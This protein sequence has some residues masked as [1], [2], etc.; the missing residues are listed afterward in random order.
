MIDSPSALTAREAFGRPGLDS[1]WATGAKEG[2]GTACTPRS[3]VWF[4]LARGI[5]TEVYY[6]RV[7]SANT[8]DLQFLITDG[9]TFF[10]EEQRDLHHRIEYLDPQALAY[11]LTNE[12]PGGRYRIVKHVVTDPEADCLLVRTRFEALVGRPADY[13]LLAPRVK[14]RG[15]GNSGEIASADGATVLTAWREDVALALAASVPV[16]RASCGFVGVSDG[17]T[18]LHQDFTMDWTFATASGGNIALTAELDFARSGEFTLALGFGRDPDEAARAALASLRKPYAEV[19]ARYVQE[20]QE[21]C[22]S[23]ADLSGQ[24]GDGGR[25]Q[26][27]SAMVLK[28]HEDKTYR[29]AFVASLSVP[30]GEAAGDSN[31]GGYHLCWPRDLVHIATGLLAVGDGAS[32]LRALE[33]LAR[34]QN[35]ADGSW[36]QNC[37]V[38]GRPYW[39]SLQLDEVAFPLLLAARLA[40]AGV[41]ADED[42][43]RYYPMVRAAALCL[44]R[45]GP[46]TPQERWEENAGYSPATLAVEIAALVCAAAFAELEAESA[47][48]RYLREVADSWSTRLEDWT[49]TRCGG[50]VSGQREYYERIA[51]VRPEELDLLGTECRVFLPIA[52]RRD[53]TEARSQCCIVD[54]GF[55]ELVRYG[56]RAADDP[57]VLKTLPVYDALL[58]VD[59]P[60]GPAWRRYN[61]DGYGEGANGEPYDGAGIG[62]AWPLL[63]G[64]RGH[65]ELAAG[66]DALSYIQAMG[67]FA[68]A[69]GMLPEQVWDADDLPE[70]GLRRGHGTGSAT[71]L[72]WAHAEYLRLLRSRRDGRV[73]D[74]IPEVYE[75][76]VLRRT[77]T[78]LVIWKFNHLVRAIGKD[79]RLRVEV[80][81][82]AEL[83]WSPDNW[84]TV[85][86]DPLVEV[87]PG[88][89]IYALEF[90][91]FTFTPGRP[92]QFTFYWPEADRWEGR[93]F[94]VAVA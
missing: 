10:H 5:I 84:T 55:L 16:L 11:R 12:D 58:R 20:W 47:L 73:F 27:I 83:H 43:R 21:W 45:C 71:P 44:A 57:H 36:P 1:R 33:Y 26:R 29:G 86:H 46:A 28:A 23:L 15:A 18:D 54:G 93:D 9:R 72:A 82:P 49:F 87:A 63:T 31:A 22:A 3:K 76:Y 59:T 88:T 48:A 34:T 66:R 70:R 79:Q 81:A 13:R 69:G 53:P 14:N 19:E 35:E 32:A 90:P 2:V 91:P 77:K 92:L 78:G 25:L 50:L 62:R 38:D 56:V 17:W 75:R 4:T 41:L 39:G 8:R 74:C 94:V 89:G 40:R 64:E 65:Y 7:D 80:A 85:H 30:W 24:S 52:N 51:V 68:N 42:R 37:W 61:H 6:P 67:R 60:N